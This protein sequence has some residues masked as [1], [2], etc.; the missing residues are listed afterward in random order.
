M[1]KIRVLGPFAAF[2]A[3]GSTIDLTARKAQ[4]VLAYLAVEGRAGRSRLAGIF[5]GGLS[6]ERARH[7]V[8][9]VLARIRA[10]C[11]D[12]VETKGDLLVLDEASVSVD[13]AEYCRLS[14]E[15]DQASMER[16]LALYTG[17]LLEG[18][19]PKEPEFQEWLLT[20]RER[21]RNRACEVM[22]RYV[23]Q[24]MANDEIERALEA[25][26]RRLEMDPA[27]EPAHRN[28][29][30]LL[31]NAGRRS[32]AIR[33]YQVCA[34]A[35][36]REIGVEPSAE[37]R[38]LLA[39]IRDSGDDEGELQHPAPREGAAPISEKPR[40]AVLP[41]ENLSPAADDYFVD[42]VTEDIITAL[43]RFH[44]LEVIARGS[45]FVY[46]G[47][48]VPDQ[49]IA[50]ALAAPYLVRGSVRRSGNRLSLQ[51]H[52]LDGP[53]NLTLWST[54]L[55]FKLDDVFLVE[56]EITATLASTL[57]GRVEA[58]RLRWA[59]RASPDRLQAYDYLLRGK[60]H[61]HRF[62]ADDCATCIDMFNRA[63]E[64]DPD[65]A[66]AHAWLACG[67]GQ[68]MVWGLDGQNDLVDRAQAEAERGLELDENEPEC[69]RVL[70]QVNL[71]RG[72][73]PRALSHQERA[74]FLN[75]NDDRSV[76]S[77]GEILC[78]AGHHEDAEEWVR[79]SLRLNPYH[80]QRYWTH[81]ARALI[82]QRRFD[83][84]LDV[85]EQIGR[86]RIDDLAYAIAA[87]VEAGRKAS[88]ARSIDA[89][90]V[91]SPEFDRE[92]FV[93]SLPYQRAADRE[94]IRGALVAAG[95]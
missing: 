25:V 46:K 29:M 37:T 6:E 27:C 34:D 28:K 66:A 71:T 19:A 33:Q 9:Q 45:T 84:A 31:T 30:A 42:G 75:P 43:S 51:V 90:R 54:R 7:N 59:R 24:L 88:A 85:L 38:A 14:T 76:C 52:L 80:P 55:D 16:C 68:A 4:G 15:T 39:R 93:E 48:A 95:L 62:T 2:S 21:L 36:Q 77:M 53:A 60:D 3:D 44:E 5:W 61:H 40:V 35:L 13:A 89:L 63:I 47:K 91:A 49:E 86:P 23:A 10:D 22:D 32:E 87:S 18:A 67:L 94:L 56:D 82:H 92:A 79:K 70:A 17:D 69:H 50:Q 72:N 8:R 83:E 65:Y 78:F 58:S 20:T 26:S 74:L 11:G 57:A 64:K 73:I 1:K 81:L 41:L 12:I